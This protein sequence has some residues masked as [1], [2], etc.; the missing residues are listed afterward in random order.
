MNLVI[1]ESPTKAKTITRFLTDDFQTESSFGHVRDLPKREMGVDVAHDFMPKYVIPLKAKKTVNKL[2]KLAAT[3]DLVYFATDQDREG[4]AIAW[5]LAQIFKTP[6]NRIKRITFHE[7]TEEAVKEA[8]QNPRAID[9]HLVDAQQARR[10]LDR[11][12]GYELSPFL[13]Q[14]V[15]KGLSAGRVQSVAVRLIVERER[16]I[17]NFKVEEYWTVEGQ[18][19][20]DN[21]QKIFQA[22]LRQID[23]KILDKFALKNE[24]EAKTVV[25]QIGQQKFI[26]SDLSSK[27]VMRLPP[28]PFT[29]STLQQEANRRLGFSAKQTMLLAQRLYEGVE[30][31]QGGAVGLITY[32]RT[33]SVNLAEKFLQEARQ[34]LLKNFGESYTTP[35]PRHFTKT[36]K[37]AQEAHEAIRPTNLN[38]EPEGLQDYLENN[39][40]RLYKLIWQRALAC[41]MAGAKLE[42]T[43]ADL[44][45]ADKKFVF[46]ANGQVVKFSGWLKVYPVTAKEEILPSLAMGQGVIAQEIKPLQHFTQPPAR[47]TDATLV[48]ALEEYG[49]GR[50]STYAPTLSTI[51]ERNYV[52]REE[53]KLKP[54]E[55]AFIVN[56]L[57]VEH[58][59]N[60]VDYQFTAKLEDDL[61]AIANGQAK[62]VPVIKEFYGPFK[63]L[64]AEKTAELNKKDIM[65]E[66]K[67]DEVCEKCGRPMVIKRGRFGKFLACS[68]FPEC[69]NTKKLAADGK[70]QATPVLLAEKCPDC[71]A[72]LQERTGRY[73]PFV[74]CSRYPDCKYIKKNNGTGVTCPQCGQGE[75]VAK[76]GRGR[77]FYACNRYPDCKFAL[78]SKPTG[79]KCPTCG[80]LL[81]YGKNNTVVCSNKECEYKKTI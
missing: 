45:S 33:D 4:E 25:Q 39:Q 54:T 70:E 51:I 21:S 50:P 24:K 67:S 35:K 28:A 41:Q 36:Q 48:K 79:D 53:K 1:V 38:L 62:W 37:L 42:T 16:E 76:R 27:S 2:K 80:S 44:Q 10:I 77:I 26:I 49:I 73:G 46:R 15:A 12:V 72:P 71:G 78:W 30:V 34:Y 19:Q 75:I 65:P 8:L 63:K 52:E 61:D 68:G 40:L 58:F 59:P 43:T 60:I 66:E 22:V 81:L 7:I 11:L 55:I 57:L 69:K 74:G 20:A 31:G 6:A 14:K 29:T 47:Y 9:L 17:Q 18:F 3:A 23:G 32:M 56:D 13:W 64:L 5:H